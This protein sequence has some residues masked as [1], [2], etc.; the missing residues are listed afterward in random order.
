MDTRDNK[1]H[2]NLEIAFNINDGKY[3]FTVHKNCRAMVLRPILLAIF[4][5]IKAIQPFPQLRRQ[6]QELRA[7]M[8]NAFK[9]FEIEN[10]KLCQKIESGDK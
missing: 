9:F 8:R 4:F 7:N 1:W 3:H 10:N 2:H 5:F 6:E